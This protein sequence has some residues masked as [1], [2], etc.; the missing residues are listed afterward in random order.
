[1]EDSSPPPRIRT[2]AFVVALTLLVAG[3][4]GGDSSTGPTAPPDAPP[5]GDL[6]A[7]GRDIAGSSGCVACHGAEGQGTVGPGWQG[8]LGSTVT[9]AD[10]TTITADEEYIRRSIVSPDADVV[11]GFTIDMP[12]VELTP[13][14]VDA[15]VAFISSL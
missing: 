8:L 12:E 6:V 11:A 14:E 1:M 13:G 5:G 15:L 3:C 9:L 10:G 2:A 4:S 7:T